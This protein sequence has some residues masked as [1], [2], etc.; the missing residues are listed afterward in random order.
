[1]FCGAL[2]FED[3]SASW[4]LRGLSLVPP[5]L[6][7]CGRVYVAPIGSG[8]MGSWQVRQSWKVSPGTVVAPLR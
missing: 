3:S 5:A 4:F 8:E 7:K 6:N 2:V 1:M